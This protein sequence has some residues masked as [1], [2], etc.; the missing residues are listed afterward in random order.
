MFTELTNV[1]KE[2]PVFIQTAF[3]DGKVLLI[4]PKK[5]KDDESG[6]LDALLGVR[7]TRRT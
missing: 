6:I 3:R 7:H 5:L 2:R 1:I 4:A